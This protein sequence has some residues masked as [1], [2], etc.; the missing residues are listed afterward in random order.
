[1]GYRCA[2]SCNARDHRQRLTINCFS[3]YIIQETDIK[4]ATIIRIIPDKHRGLGAL[5]EL[6]HEVTNITGFEHKEEETKKA[7]ESDCVDK[8][9]DVAW[10]FMTGR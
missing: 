2:R 4:K 10:H 9:N 5:C 3:F 6:H 1:M 8:T 7:I